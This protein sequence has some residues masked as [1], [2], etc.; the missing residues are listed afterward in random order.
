MFLRL[1]SSIIAGNPQNMIVSQDALSV[2]S[3]SLFL[4]YQVLPS[5]LSWLITTYWIQ[6]CWRANKASL[7]H[8]KLRTNENVMIV[9]SVTGAVLP[10]ISV[11]TTHKQTTTHRYFLPRQTTTSE[12]SPRQ[13]RLR[14]NMLSKV[15]YIVTSPIPLIATFIILTM[16][17]LI[18]LNVLS[19]AA[20]VCI[21]AVVLV[22]VLVVGNHIRG[23]HIW[24]RAEDVD[25]AGA[26]GRPLFLTGAAARPV[27]AGPLQ[28]R[29]WENV[30]RQVY[31]F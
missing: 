28:P 13:R 31:T 22:V 10:S 30:S 8:V 6:R 11:D 15:S 29:H 19:I 26:L 5:L 1:N 18:F 14:E 17:I 7:V 21:T 20:L 4:A 9:N 12:M 16:I 24:R 3:P 23:Q 2:M 25:S 27:G